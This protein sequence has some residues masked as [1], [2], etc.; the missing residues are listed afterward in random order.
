MFEIICHNSFKKLIYGDSEAA[1]AL[2]QLFPSFVSSWSVLDLPDG[3]NTPSCVRPGEGLVPGW[4]RGP[5]SLQASAIHADEVCGCQNDNGFWASLGEMAKAPTA[6]WLQGSSEK[7]EKTS[8]LTYPMQSEL[9][10][11]PV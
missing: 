1:P 6:F 3:V 8:A 10:F 7:A 11:A 2:L 9:W 5:C 4:G